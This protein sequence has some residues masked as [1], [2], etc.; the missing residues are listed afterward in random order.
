MAHNCVLIVAPPGPLR[1]GLRALLR[2]IPNVQIVGVVAHNKR[3]LQAVSEGRAALV[4]LDSALPGEGFVPLLQQLKAKWPDVQCVVLTDNDEQRRQAQ[5]AEADAVLLKGI[6]AARLSAA[7]ESLL[8]LD[9]QLQ[10]AAGG[11][12]R[13]QHRDRSKLTVARRPKKGEDNE[14]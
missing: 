12:C 10:P 2:S 1:H 4:L 13:S 6:P 7:V 14:A 9:G 8:A 5:A 11:R 3:A